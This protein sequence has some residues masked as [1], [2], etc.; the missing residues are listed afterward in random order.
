VRLLVLGDSLTFHGPDAAHPPSD[1]RLWPNVMARHL[2]ADVDVAAG[3]GW[4]ARDAWW[5]VT[6][7]PMIWG[8]Y[9]PRADALVIA[10]GGMDSLPAVI[11]T[12]VRQG[13]SFIRPGWVRR[14][15][16]AAYLTASPV[17]IRALRGPLRQLPQA[18][19]DHY[20]SRIVQAVRH[21]YPD[22]PIVFLTPAPHRAALYPTLRFYRPAVAAAY[23]WTRRE[24][25]TLV[26][27]TGAAQRGLDNGWTN[28][29]GMHWGWQTHA[30]IGALVAGALRS[31]SVP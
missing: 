2:G 28:P 16:R 1:P 20:L 15:V 19:T 24:G 9:L 8:E 18:A 22:L 4:T 14:R 6:R 7:D 17:A 25:V 31:P 10:V 3:I 23:Q 21:W 12:Y 26:D 13:I 29:D 5:A 11:P 27:I 30:E